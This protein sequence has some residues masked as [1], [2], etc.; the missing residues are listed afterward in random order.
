MNDTN[1]FIEFAK[2]CHASHFP[3]YARRRFPGLPP[4]VHQASQARPQVAEDNM[5][6]VEA[7]GIDRM[8]RDL[9]TIFAAEIRSWSW[10]FL[11]GAVFGSYLS[12]SVAMDHLPEILSIYRPGAPS[13]GK[14]E[15]V[16]AKEKAADLARTAKEKAT[17]AWNNFK[18]NR[19]AKR[20]NAYD[21][22]REG[23]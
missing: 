19:Q 14:R 22:A 13:T 3:A 1:F 5:A 9:H 6:I 23:R 10:V 2:K 4:E 18:E 20:D 8:R 16:T 15:P 12:I 7:A 11:I 21:A 17:S